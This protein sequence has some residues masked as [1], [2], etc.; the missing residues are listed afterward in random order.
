LDGAPSPED[1]KELEDHVAA[2]KRAAVNTRDA[3][4]GAREQS[5]EA[6]A[7]RKSLRATSAAQH[8]GFDRHLL[9]AK[10]ARREFTSK[11]AVA[12]ALPSSNDTLASAQTE[13][14][15]ALKLATRW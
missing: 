3:V 14:G 12:K 15:Q 11:S 10:K 4:A 13:F 5:S 6:A 2:S 7:A 8:A 9:T 1:V